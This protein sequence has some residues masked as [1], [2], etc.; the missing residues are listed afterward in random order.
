VFKSNE[1]LYDCDASVLLSVYI[2][3]VFI[4]D[5]WLAL[6]SSYLPH[7]RVLSLVFC[8]KVRNKYIKE[9]LVAVPELK[10]TK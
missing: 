7:L 8:D 4:G 9:L 3:L 5:G 1:T 10:V 2:Y 6:L